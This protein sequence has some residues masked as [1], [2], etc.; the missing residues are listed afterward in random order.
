M[1]M[2][3]MMQ[4]WQKVILLILEIL[5][6]FYGTESKEGIK[7]TLRKEGTETLRTM[8]RMAHTCLMFCCFSLDSFLF[9]FVVFQGKL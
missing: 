2:P 1:T 4:N 6:I 7:E 3:K 9:A 8:F 5:Y